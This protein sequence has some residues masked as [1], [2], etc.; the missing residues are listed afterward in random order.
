MHGNTNL[1]ICRKCGKDYMRDYRTRTAK[2]VKEHQTGRICDNPK[3]KGLLYD[4][5]INFGEDLKEDVID[6]AFAEG[7]KC[8]LMVAMGSS[9]R[10]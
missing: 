8:D 5:I 1:E 3:C 6:R 9:L 10:V 2:K 7:K 4:S